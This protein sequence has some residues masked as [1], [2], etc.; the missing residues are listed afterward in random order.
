MKAVKRLLPVAGITG[1][2]LIISFLLYSGIVESGKEK[3]WQELSSTTELVRKEI[4]TKLQDE[5]VKLHLIEAAMTQDGILERKDMKALQLDVF[6]ET[7]I[8]SRID[9]LYPDDT[10]LL[11]GT[12][13]VKYENVSFEEMAEKGEHLTGRE[14]DYETGKECIYYMM[15]VENGSEILLMLIGVIESESL[16]EVFQPVIYDGKANICIVDVESGNYIMDTWHKELGN[17]Y[18]TEDRKRIKG[19]EAVDLK[20]ELRTYQTGAIAFES[21]TNGKPIYMYY[22]PVELFDWQ[23]AIFAQED[24]IFG[25]LLSL[26]KLCIFAAVTEALLL[27]LYFLWNIRTVRLLEKSNAEIEKQKEQLRHISYI[28]MLTSTYNRNKYIEVL[29]LLRKQKPEKVGIAYIDLNGL[30]QINDL[31]SHEAGD[32]YI[33]GTAKVISEIFTG[34]CY[35][36]GGDEFVILTV[37]MEREEFIDRVKVLKEIVK[38]QKISISVGSLW[39]EFCEN[40][41]ELVKEAERRMYEEKESYYLTHSREALK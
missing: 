28:D 19:Y 34:S 39:E 24:V 14:T 7:T 31:H 10:L 21:R 17:A 23:L 8:F 35:R 33:R 41:D 29:S 30:K 32:D 11:G 4:T 20:E 36:I 6:V 5:M 38:Q 13:K 26:Q 37:N 40:L 25:Y 2:I 12:K 18:E 22:T 15:P 9:V 16:S 1:V 3:C 27:I